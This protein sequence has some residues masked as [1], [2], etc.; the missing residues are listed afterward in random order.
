MAESV[1]KVT[2]KLKEIIDRNGLAYLT[3]KPYKVYKELIQSEAADRKAAGLILY[4]LVNDVQSEAEPG[5]DP[6]SLSKE[7]QRRCSLNKKAA[8]YLSAVFLTLYSKEM[9]TA[10]GKRI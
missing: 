10:G 3:E 9:R 7:I 6:T 8:D 4:A 5:G 2:T 1:E